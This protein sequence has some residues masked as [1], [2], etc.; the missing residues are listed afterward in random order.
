[1]ICDFAVSSFL[2]APF[3]WEGIYKKQSPCLYY[4]LV[5]G[6]QSYKK[7]WHEEKQ[8]MPHFAIEMFPQARGNPVWMMFSLCFHSFHFERVVFM[9]VKPNKYS[10]L[11]LGLGGLNE[12]IYVF[13][14]T[15]KYLSEQR[16][17]GGSLC[18]GIRNK[19]DFWKYKSAILYKIA[20]PFCLLKEKQFAL[21]KAVINS[22]VVTWMSN[23]HPLLIT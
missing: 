17:R 23:T 13:Y 14:L 6:Q 16:F 5:E 7:T 2:L 3:S 9:R 10:D 22:F 12:I 18:I 21:K 11:I 15:K 20:V 19:T 8:L 1:M 4:F